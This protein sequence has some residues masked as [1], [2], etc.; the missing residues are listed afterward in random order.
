MINEH[1]PLGVPWENLV[2]SLDHYIGTKLQALREERSLGADK[3]AA[4]LSIP[5]EDYSALELGMRP[6]SA[7][8]LYQLCMVFDV[9]VMSFFDGY[10][11]PRRDGVP[12]N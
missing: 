12:E 8:Y 2:L 9:S 4:L 11:N 1:R 6:I 3:I 10:E 7:R 5:D